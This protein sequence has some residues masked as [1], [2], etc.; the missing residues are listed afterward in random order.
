M[1]DAST[2]NAAAEL[3]GAVHGRLDV[4]VN[5]AVI[6]YDTWQSAIGADLDVV[7]QALEL[8]SD[9]ILVNS[10]CPGWVATDMGGS[11]GRPVAEGAAG[12]TWAATLPD[13]GPSG[14]HVRDR[15]PILW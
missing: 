7:R 2:A 15:Q 14:G 10:V 3:I 1:T 9:H 4:L 11:G 5:N 12:I 6:H 8:D 13:D